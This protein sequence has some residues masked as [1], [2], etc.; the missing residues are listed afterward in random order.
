LNWG[1]NDEQGERTDPAKPLPPGDKEPVV[2]GPAPVEKEKSPSTVAPPTETEKT[3]KSGPDNSN[4]IQDQLHQQMEKASERNSREPE[5]KGPK[6]AEVKAPAEGHP[7]DESKP[8]EK[9]QAPVAAPARKDGENSDKQEKSG[10]RNGGDGL[11]ER[12]KAGEKING[13]QVKAVPVEVHPLE[14]PNGEKPGV[15]IP[16]LHPSPPANILDKAIVVKGPTPS[17]AEHAPE[18][19]DK[20]PDSIPPLGA[21]A[22]AASPVI[23]VPVPPAPIDG[24]TTVVPRVESYEVETY[25]ARSG[26]TLAGISKTY[27]YGD[28]Y[29]DALLK[30]N[31]E[32]HQPSPELLRDP[33]EL[34]AGQQVVIPPLWVLEKKYAA[35]IP[36]LKPI[37]DTQPPVLGTP[38]PE[39]SGPPADERTSRSA[40]VVI[41]ASGQ[42]PPTRTREYKVAAGGELFYHIAKARL[43]N[44]NRWGEIYQLNPGFAPEIA[45][46]AGT[47]LRLPAD[48]RVEG[49]AAGN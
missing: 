34:T 30:F 48:A 42:A 5:A 33:P 24:K 25:Q 10:G 38:V 14:K 39:K 31:R 20:V 21:P 19:P 49:P 4:L 7:G 11:T 46:P 16:V 32:F 17:S 43:G 44:A 37:R 26:D 6:P 15:P 40:P 1:N 12:E 9:T 28:K 41:Q 29:K 3:G 22:P 47:L 8:W 36:N 27:Y 35:L 13:E 18:P 23:P 2:E 45:V